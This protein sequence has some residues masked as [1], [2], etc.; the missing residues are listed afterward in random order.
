MDP[1]DTT[2]TFREVR[3]IRNQVG[4]PRSLLML[5][6]PK[7]PKSP[8][9]AGCLGATQDGLSVSPSRHP[10]LSLPVEGPE[11][12]ADLLMPAGA[13]NSGLSQGLELSLHCVTPVTCVPSVLLGFSP[14]SQPSVSVVSASME[15]LAAELTSGLAWAGPQGQSFNG[16]TFGTCAIHWP[17][18]PWFFTFTPRLKLLGGQEFVT[19]DKPGYPDTQMVRLF[20]AQQGSTRTQVNE[21]SIPIRHGLVRAGHPVLPHISCVTLGK[22]PHLSE[23]LFLYL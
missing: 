12:T 15:V 22:S 19:L 21:R 10:T 3:L 11:D 6:T 17:M 8:L 9:Q 23:L 1:S 16:G 7:C 14:A 4:L 20:G 13:A 2:A 18:S 5:G